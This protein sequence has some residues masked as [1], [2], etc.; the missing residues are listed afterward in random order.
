[1]SS[2]VP[3]RVSVNDTHPIGWSIALVSAVAWLAGVPWALVHGPVGLQWVVAQSFGAAVIPM[4]AGWGTLWG[5]R[6][7]RKAA[8]RVALGASAILFALELGRTGQ[9]W[10]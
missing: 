5:T 7:D 8:V 10:G 9:L 1:M 6:G 3:T 4:V 2:P